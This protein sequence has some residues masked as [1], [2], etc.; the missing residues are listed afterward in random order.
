MISTPP[1]PIR[2]QRLGAVLLIAAL[3]LASARAGDGFTSELVTGSLGLPIA[4]A[5]TSAGRVL[6]TD[7]VD[8]AGVGTCN[9]WEVV[10]GVLQTPAWATVSNCNQDG[11]QGLLGITLDPSYVEPGGRAGKLSTPAGVGN[12]F[13]YVYLNTATAHPT[14]PSAL[15]TRI[16]R[17]TD[18]GS[19]GTNPTTVIDNLPNST[20]ATNHDGG[21]IHFGPD[22]YFYLSLG[23]DG[24]NACNSQDLTTYNGKILRYDA[25]TVPFSSIPSNPFFVDNMIDEPRDYF[26]SIGERN[27]FDFT[28]H[29][30]SE[31][32]F[33]TENGPG[34]RDEINDIGSGDNLG[35][36]K[37]YGGAN[38]TVACSSC[39]GDGVCNSCNGFSSAAPQH[40]YLTT[41]APTG[42]TTNQGLHYPGSYYRDL[43]WV[44]NNT[45]SV[46]HGELNSSFDTIVSV[47]ES[48]L[49][50]GLG[51]LFDI[52]SAP[53][54]LLYFT[55]INGQLRRIVYTDPLRRLISGSGPG[56][57][58]RLR[59]F[60]N[61]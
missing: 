45:G 51:A 30:V 22:G 10:D 58:S 43:F 27:S 57:A 59:H 31:I 38:C 8:F 52:E 21:N 34:T 4:M 12:S 26:F 56:G 36:P 17:F 2:P 46:R 9:I 24:N 61:S 40:C 47:N 33:A 60:E 41:I 28:F 25:S 18:T 11:E 7:K 14:V 55:G 48:F 49:T 20:A 23:D 32:L 13:V 15:I 44:D 54:G 39:C 3:P 6:I 1:R 50:P 37:Q 19:S 42:I 29:P 35:W 53:D 5:W 16:L